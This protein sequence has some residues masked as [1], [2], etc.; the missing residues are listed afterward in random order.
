VLLLGLA[1]AFVL[2]QDRVDRRDPKL[3]LAPIGSDVAEFA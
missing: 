3:R 2:I 1:I